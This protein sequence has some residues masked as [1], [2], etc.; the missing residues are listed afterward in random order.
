MLNNLDQLSGLNQLGTK[1]NDFNPASVFTLGQQG[2]W[3]EILPNTLWQDTAR[4]IPV[5]ADG[6]S[7]ASLQ[8]KTASGSVYAEQATAENRPLYRFTEG[9]HYLQFDGANGYLLTSAIDCT[10]SNAMFCSM[11]LRK[12]SDAAFGHA[13]SLGDSATDDGILAMRAPSGPGLPTL[14][15]AFKLGGTLLTSAT[16]SD[17]PAGTSYI[18]TG[19]VDNLAPVRRMRVNG[20]QVYSTNTAQSLGF[21]GN[22]PVSLGAKTSGTSK[23]DGRLYSGVMR[24]GVLPDNNTLLQIERWVASKSGITI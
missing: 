6:Q 8:L 20:V 5:T 4:T 3:W 23:F 10:A 1:N 19:I 15:L 16:A 22:L 14:G 17:Y 24:G 2:F 18:Y 21:F 7:V 13:L 11:G 9:L 12:N